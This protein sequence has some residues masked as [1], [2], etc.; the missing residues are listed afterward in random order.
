MLWATREHLH[1]DR[2]ATA[3]LIL[4]F[5]DTQAQFVYVSDLGSVPDGAVA[6][7]F[8]GVELSSHDGHGTTFAKTLRSRNISEPALELM[9]RMVA[10]G[11]R[12][13]FGHDSQES[14]PDVRA[15]AEALDGIGVGMGALFDDDDALLF[16]ALPL[17]DAVYI[18]SQVW[19][20]PPE[21]RRQVPP[22]PP[23]L[24]SAYLRQTLRMPTSP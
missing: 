1:L 12:H 2:V 16:A 24:R 15:V 11:I 23:A 5:V 19:T 21:Q 17:Y 4:R 7:G 6:F 20:L 13:V 3:W 8:P 18:L 10:E 14:D 22:G 9:E